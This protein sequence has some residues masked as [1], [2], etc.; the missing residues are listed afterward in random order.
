[1]TDVA[2][3]ETGVANIASMLVALERLGAAPSLTKDPER[4]ADAPFVVLPGVGAFGAGAAELDRMN[5]RATLTERIGAGRPTLCVCLGLQLLTRAS[6]ESPGVEGLGIIPHRVERFTG[7]LRVPQLGWNRVTPSPDGT[8]RFLT[9]AGH[10][11]FANSFRLGTQPE[12]WTCATCD[13]GGSFVA[14]MER[15]GVLACQFHPELSGAWGQ[16]VMR[17][18]LE[19]SR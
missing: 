19:Q 3:I 10:A 12:G 2:V 17:R 16:D 1:M 13:Y 9:D 4:V 15:G 6:E 8:P 11:Y 5:M 7:E 14:A 18:W